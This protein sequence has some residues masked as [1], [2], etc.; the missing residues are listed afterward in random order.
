MPVYDPRGSGSGYWFTIHDL[1]FLV[2]LGGIAVA[3]L[4]LRSEMRVGSTPAAAPSNANF[5]KSF[6]PIASVTK[7]VLQHKLG[8]KQ[9]H[10]AVAD[11]KGGGA[12]GAAASLL[13]QFF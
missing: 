10:R 3:A 12:V 5:R 9:A 7:L 8:G 2:L 13:S 4:D 11:S 1:L 6:A